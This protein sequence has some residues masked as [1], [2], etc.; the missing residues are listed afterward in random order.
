MTETKPEGAKFVNNG[1]TIHDDGIHLRFSRRRM[2]TFPSLRG[3]GLFSSYALG[4]ACFKLLRTFICDM[5][6]LMFQNEQRTS[7]KARVIPCSHAT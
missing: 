6:L 2:P 5:S 7:F 1:T 4:Y 3:T